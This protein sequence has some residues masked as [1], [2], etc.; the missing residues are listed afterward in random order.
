MTMETELSPPFL[1]SPMMWMR[2]APPALGATPAVAVE[3]D[4]VPAAAVEVEADEVPAV[5]LT[6]DCALAVA[7]EEEEAPPAAA[8]PT[9]CKSD[10]AAPLAD[11]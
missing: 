2:A 11:F 10:P 9:C 4:E 7:E 8:L 3:E 5:A 1:T 6:A